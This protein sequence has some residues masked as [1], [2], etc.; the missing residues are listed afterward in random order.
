MAR[1]TPPARFSNGCII[2]CPS[3]N[4]DTRGPMYNNGDYWRQKFHTCADGT[5]SKGKATV[6]AA[7]DRTINTDVACGDKDDLWYYTPWRYPGSSPVL[8]SCG[9]AGGHWW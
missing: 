6:C 4:G 5:L 3:C 2:G 1:S 8:D 9:V 7:E